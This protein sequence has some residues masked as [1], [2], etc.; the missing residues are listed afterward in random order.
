MHTAL[1]PGI[2]RKTSSPLRREFA[3][4]SKYI[5]YSCKKLPLTRIVNN[6]VCIGI[7]KP[8]GFRAGCFF[9]HCTRC[10]FIAFLLNIPPHKEQ[11]PFVFWI[12]GFVLSY[13]DGSILGMLDRNS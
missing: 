10:F 2:L 13:S 1:N 12:L 6:L 3:G 5:Q 7:E 9:M 4:A 11:I 8:D